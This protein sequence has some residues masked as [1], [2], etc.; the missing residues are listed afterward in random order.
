MVDPAVNK[1]TLSRMQP[2]LLV[3]RAEDHFSF[4]YQRN[5]NL[6]MPMTDAAVIG[7]RYDLPVHGDRKISCSMLRQFLQGIIHCNG[8]ALHEIPPLVAFGF[9][10][11]HNYMKNRI[12]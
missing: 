8:S 9:N 5:L 1:K 11:A 10:S 3:I 7:I 2:N 12:K 6:L 4:C